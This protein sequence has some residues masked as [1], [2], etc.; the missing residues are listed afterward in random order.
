MQ[1]SSSTPRGVYVTGTDTGVGKT[2]ASAALLHAVRATGVT[3][4][5]MKPV[6]SGSIETGAGW[7]NEDALALQAAASAGLAYDDIN[8]YALPLPT[9]PQLAARAAGI[10]VRL[11][12][13]LAAHARLVAAAGTVVVEGVGGWM[14]PLADGCEQADL[15]R[16]LRLPVILVVG[17]RLGCLSHA[18]LSARAIA[19]DGCVLAGWIGSAVEAGFDADGHYRALLAS[20]LAAP[21]LGRLAH[22]PAPDPAELAGQLTLPP[23]LS[24][25]RACAPG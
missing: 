15:V 8:P 20:A 13:L 7:R 21:C 19:A 12:V 11:D 2:L 4:A 3:V 18:R 17:L 22:M 6:A 10:E 16:A 14:A 5:G 1:S 25:E 9:A 24:P 23:A